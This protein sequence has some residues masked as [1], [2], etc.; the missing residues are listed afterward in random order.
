MRRCDGVHRELS[1]SIV[2]VLGSWGQLTHVGTWKPELG[3]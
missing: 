1:K 3:V 2:V